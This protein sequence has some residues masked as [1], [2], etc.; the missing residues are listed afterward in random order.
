MVKEMVR[1]GPPIMLSLEFNC[2]EVGV[3][4][5]SSG[6]G[7]GPVLSQ[8][9]GSTLWFPVEETQG[10]FRVHGRAVWLDKLITEC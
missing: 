1:V 6:G 7:Q 5:V 10:G 2:S 3:R 8:G 9:S 4:K